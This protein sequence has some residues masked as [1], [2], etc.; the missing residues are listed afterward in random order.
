M[1]HFDPEALLL[2]RYFLFDFSEELLEPLDVFLAGK[3]LGVPLDLAE[4]FMLE[5]S[6]IVSCNV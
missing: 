1:L 3:L 6:H 2:Q 5:L 4:L